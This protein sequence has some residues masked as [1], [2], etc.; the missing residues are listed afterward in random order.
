MDW[1]YVVIAHGFMDTARR[2]WLRSVLETMEMRATGRYDC[3][4]SGVPT[5]ELCLGIGKIHL[6]SSATNISNNYQIHQGKCLPVHEK[7][8]LTTTKKWF[9]D[10][11]ILGF[12]VAGCWIHACAPL[13]ASPFDARHRR[14]SKPTA[15]TVCHTSQPPSRRLPLHVASPISATT[16]CAATLGA[17]P[18]LTS[19]RGPSRSAW[20]RPPRVVEAQTDIL[21]HASFS[22]IVGGTER[23]AERDRGEGGI[24]RQGSEREGE[25]DESVRVSDSHMYIMQCY[26][27]KL[28]R[29]NFGSIPYKSFASENRFTEADNLRRSPP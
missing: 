28:G 26:R 5:I 11:V 10:R 23:G 17:A 8:A 14:L 1:I 18:D 29:G 6:F 22:N 3:I 2:W 16:G 21:A 25:E 12:Q 27:T 13:H 19:T 7:I 24:A 20:L 4:D 15:T 9:S